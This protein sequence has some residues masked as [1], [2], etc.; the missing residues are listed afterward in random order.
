MLQ[1]V[2]LL[3]SSFLGPVIL[4]L[5]SG[6]RKTFGVVNYGYISSK[7]FSTF[8]FGSQFKYYL[9]ICTFLLFY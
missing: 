5:E 4:G 3:E 2:L 1:G 8:L 7:L 9:Y 6:V